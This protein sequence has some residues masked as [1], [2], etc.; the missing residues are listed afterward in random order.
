MTETAGGAVRRPRDSTTGTEAIGT[1][2][3]IPTYDPKNEGVAQTRDGLQAAG[4]FVIGWIKDRAGSFHN[5]LY[6]L[7]GFMV[8]A[9]VVTVADVG[10]RAA[11][12]RL[13][14]SRRPR[15][16]RPKSCWTEKFRCS[17]AVLPFNS[18]ARPRKFRCLMA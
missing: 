5:S 8:L 3:N 14:R 16:N 1:V 4:P 15:R 17:S 10:A 18:P 13:P 6:A 9:A 2:G 12:R 11:N 7:S